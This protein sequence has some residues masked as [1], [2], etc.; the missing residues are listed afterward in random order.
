MLLSWTQHEKLQGCWNVEFQSSNSNSWKI[1]WHRVGY[2]GSQRCSVV[3]THAT[4][5][6]IIGDAG[7]ACASGMLSYCPVDKFVPKVNLCVFIGHYFSGLRCGVLNTSH[8]YMRF[9]TCWIWVQPTALLRKVNCAMLTSASSPT[10]GRAT[11]L[12]F[13]CK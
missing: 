10:F 5:T 7:F 6:T 8:Q 1:T 2:R 4:P 9:H 12:R 13:N 11:K 3:K